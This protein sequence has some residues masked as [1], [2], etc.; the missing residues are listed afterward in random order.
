MN[1][2]V[3]WVFGLL[4]TLLLMV[5]PYL[6]SASRLVFGIAIFLL[7]VWAFWLMMEYLRWAKTLGKK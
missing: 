2:A 5:T 7:C 4:G 1:S 3:K 6:W